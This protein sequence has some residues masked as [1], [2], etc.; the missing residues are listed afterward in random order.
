VDLIKNGV[1]DYALKDKLFSLN[2]KITRALKEAE[3]KKK[4][5]IADEK[6]RIQNEKLFEIAFLQSHQVRSPISAILGW[7]DLFNLEDPQDPINIEVIKNL[8]KTT[9]DF[10]NIVRMIVKKTNEIKAIRD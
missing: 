8:H 5:R 6:L 9:T 3:E 7:V 4:K 1:T 2:Q 10:D